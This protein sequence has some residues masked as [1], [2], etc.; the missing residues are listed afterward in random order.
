VRRL[1]WI[2]VVIVLVAGCGG[3]HGA[4]PPSKAE[5]RAITR[6]VDHEW[7]Y[8]SSFSAV[9]KLGLHGVV[10]KIRISQRDRH[11]AEADVAGLDNHGKQGIET[12]Q[13]GLVLVAGKW[14]I[15][16]GPG[17]DLSEICTASSPQALVDLFCR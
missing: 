16:I 10:T 4:R 7:H 3:S 6:L 14:T 13:L 15:A 17:T 5:R 1:S 12:A 9:R 8:A 11:F 2:A